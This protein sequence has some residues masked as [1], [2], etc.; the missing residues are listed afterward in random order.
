[1]ELGRETRK[2]D[3]SKVDLGAV[4]MGRGVPRARGFVAMPFVEDWIL[5]QTWEQLTLL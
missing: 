1:M 3:G 4:V 2:S 5:V